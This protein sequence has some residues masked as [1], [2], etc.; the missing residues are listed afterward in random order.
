MALHISIYSNKK[1]L[2]I[3]F[4]ILARHQSNKL[5]KVYFV[6]H[7]CVYFQE[8]AKALQISEKT[9][10]KY[11]DGPVEGEIGALTRKR[12]KP[13]TDDLGEGQRLEIR[14]EIYNMYAER[15]YLFCDIPN[16]KLYHLYNIIFLFFSAGFLTMFSEGN[17]LTNN[18]INND[19]LVMVKVK[20]TYV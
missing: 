1:I 20:V 17:K 16:I 6:F 13:M 19:S 9:T 2:I 8:T 10:R 7:K 15:K 11:K 12:S 3:T 14:D 18:K 5:A 4:T